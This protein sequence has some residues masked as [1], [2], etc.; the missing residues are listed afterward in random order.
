MKIK[1]DETFENW[2]NKEI[3]TDMLKTTLARILARVSDTKE[4]ILLREYVDFL[5]QSYRLKTQYGKHEVPVEI[6]GIHHEET[7][8]V[9]EKNE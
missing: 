3:T 7:K 8:Q 6:I 2:Y 4:K 9:E 1:I 5:I